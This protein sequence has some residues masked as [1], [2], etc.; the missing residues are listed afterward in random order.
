MQKI[1]LQP[2]QFDSYDQLADLAEK[3]PVAP[4]AATHLSAEVAA[5]LRNRLQATGATPANLQPRA[6]ERGGTAPKADW[7]SRFFAELLLLFLFAQLG[8]MGV[9][10]AVFAKY[11]WLIAIV[12]SPI[13]VGGLAVMLPL[14]KRKMQRH[15]SMVARSEARCV[16][17][18]YNLHGLSD[19]IPHEWIAAHVGPRRCP[20]CG[21]P[22]PLVPR[23]G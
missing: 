17:C 12:L 7:S 23:S 10:Y 1:I 2:S 22:W 3:A 13:I 21:E 14:H 16:E 15:R 19:S 20:E 18:N 4:Q 6:T 8:A 11:W 5:D 9:G